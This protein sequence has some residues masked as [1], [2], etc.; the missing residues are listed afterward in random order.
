[1]K[2]RA[3]RTDQPSMAL[4][5]QHPWR[6]S[7]EDGSNIELSSTERVELLQIGEAVRVNAPAAPIFM[8]GELATH[9]YYLDEGV[10]QGRH[11][12]RSGVRQ[13]VA[14]FW[15]GDF[16]GVPRD[17]YFFN[18]AE[19]VTDCTVY[20]FPIRDL[21]K[22]LPRRPRIQQKLLIKASHD[23]RLAQRRLVVMGTLDVTRRLAV[24]LL[25]CCGHAEHFDHG[26][27]VLTVPVSRHDIAEHIGTSSETVTR[28]MNAL[29]GKGLL[30]RL[31]PW[32][33]ELK[34]VELFAFS[35]L[36]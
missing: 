7:D 5:A 3:A 11:T 9:L 18:S 2:L 29:E 34:P 30:K 15:P 23:I 12:I 21:E 31:T 27:Q 24:F 26:S 14:L 1:M 10:V 6:S 36:D 25:D 19:A 35:G 16:F 33:L 17:G 8:Q 4:R 28:A 22:F 13:S 20:K 32:K